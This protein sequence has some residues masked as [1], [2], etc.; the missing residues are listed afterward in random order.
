MLSLS[1]LTAIV[2]LA[3]FTQT[4]TGFG[5]AVVVVALGVYL[6]PVGEL[7][8]LIVPLVTAQASWVVWTD[9]SD[10]Q[11][12]LLLARIVPLVAVGVVVGQVL[13]RRLA[14][15]WMAPAFGVLVVALALTEL[16]KGSP[17]RP[18]PRSLRGLALLL[19]GLMQ[20]LFAAGG[21]AL[22]YALGRS[23]L[24]KTQLRATV[25]ALWALVNAGM[26]AGFLV[27]GRLGAAQGG[28]LCVLALAIERALTA[29]L[30]DGTSARAAFEEL[31]TV[32]L[33][34]V[35]P[36]RASKSVR[37]VTTP[38]AAQRTC[39][40]QLGMSHLSKSPAP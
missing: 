36:D 7:V 25:C 20:G 40:K 33:I 1:L 39:L 21:P 28:D 32:R 13:F 4:L 35:A 8:P 38:S 5:F 29:A 16:F 37:V 15:P 19:S 23:D 27:D 22:A 11:G 24:T 3:S 34:D 17:D 6:R 18:L 30:P 26:T 12:R 2:A 10:V 14:G 9:R 31:Q